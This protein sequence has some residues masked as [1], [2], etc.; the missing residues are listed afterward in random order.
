MACYFPLWKRGTK[1]D[2]QTLSPLEKGDEGGFADVVDTQTLK[3]P[4]DPAST[5]SGQA[6]FRT[7]KWSSEITRRMSLV[8]FNKL[9]TQ[10]AGWLN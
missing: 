9:L 6:L 4:L 3:I 7:G 10:T 2:L 8:N 1:G 5:S